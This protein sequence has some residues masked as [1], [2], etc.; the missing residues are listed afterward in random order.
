MAQE[1]PS[2]WDM[3]TWQSILDNMDIEEE[4]KEE[5]KKDEDKDGEVTS[6]GKAWDDG[7][8]EQFSG[9][10]HYRLVYGSVCDP[11]DMWT[12]YFFL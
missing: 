10:K 8:F 9:L 12:I 1:D 11:L 4:S 2:S 6:K 5:E 7:R 3:D